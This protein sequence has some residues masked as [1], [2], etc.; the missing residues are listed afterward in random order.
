MWSAST[1]H[2][3]KKRLNRNSYVVDN[4]FQYQAIQDT[5]SNSIKLS[6]LTLFQYICQ[7]IFYLAEEHNESVTEVYLDNEIDSFKDVEYNF[8]CFFLQH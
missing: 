6:L 7:T 5:K 8:S 2:R 3:R 1:I 4:T